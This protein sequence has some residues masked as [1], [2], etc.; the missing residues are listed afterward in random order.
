MNKL[1]NVAQALAFGLTLA[2][3]LTLNLQVSIAEAHSL[4]ATLNPTPMKVSLA[5][6]FLSDTIQS[7]NGD[8]QD[9]SVDGGFQ[10]QWVNGDY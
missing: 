10:V 3:I 5:D 2:A 1:Q 7:V 6:Q 4:N 9:Q 8:Y